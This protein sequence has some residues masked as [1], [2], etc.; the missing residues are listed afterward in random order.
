[1]MGYYSWT[2]MLFAGLICLALLILIIVVIVRL[3]GRPMHEHMRNMHEE[4]MG[5][6]AAA[7]SHALEIL[8]ERF[9]KGEI[10][11]EQFTRMKGQLKQ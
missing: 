9:A 6:G 4:H 1:M 7:K 5:E 2:G 10:T 11:E 3:V 8:E